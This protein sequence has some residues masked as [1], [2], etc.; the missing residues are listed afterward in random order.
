[1]FFCLYILPIYSVLPAQFS[2]PITILQCF[3]NLVFLPIDLFTVFY[4]PIITLL[5]NVYRVGQCCSVFYRFLQCLQ[6]CTVFYLFGFSV[7]VRPQLFGILVNFT[8][9]DLDNRTKQS[10]R[11]RQLIFFISVLICLDLNPNAPNF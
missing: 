10:K 11:I 6:Y 5:Y 2:L 1:M 4:L 9:W 8:T 7:P 3:V